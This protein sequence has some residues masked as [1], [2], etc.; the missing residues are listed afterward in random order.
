MAA[1]PHGAQVEALR[2]FN[3]FYTKEIGV[4][5]EG[6]LQTRYTLTQARVVFELGKRKRAS[7]SEIAAALGLDLGYLSRIVQRFRA[8]GLVARTKSAEDGR[9]AWLTLTARGRKQFKTFDRRSR[10]EVSALI[11]RLPAAHRTR[12]VASLRNAQSILSSEK[13][14]PAGRIA[15]RP[16]RLGDIGWAI[17]RHAQVYADEFGWNAEFEALVAKLFA[18]FANEHDR[19]QERCWIAELD[20]ERAGCVFVVRNEDDPSM[21][22]LRCL[23]V[24]PGA[25]GF[26]IGRRLV[27][28]CIAFARSVGYPKMILW[29]NDVLISARRIY[30]AAGFKLIKEEPHRSFGKDL[31]G[32]FWMLGLGG[33]R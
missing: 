29:T 17:E 1:A 23:L 15:I 20:G 28:Q 18:G 32:Q 14:R 12:L 25:R 27:D 16:Y 30:E 13:R 11:G 21:A 31:V 3:R 2:S 33:K 6:L 22:Q 26:G 8:Q 4:L 19:A 24:E 10:D 7:A 9:R 5:G